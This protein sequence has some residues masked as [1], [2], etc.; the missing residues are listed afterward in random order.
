MVL[1]NS[2]A[3]TYSASLNKRNCEVH[4]KTCHRCGLEFELYQY[5]DRDAKICMGCRKPR[6]VRVY[7]PRT[8]DKLSAREAQVVELVASGRRN[9]EIAF[10]LHLT[11]GTI[12]V[13]VSH[14]FRKTGID[15][16]TGL[17][18]WW[19]KK[20]DNLHVSE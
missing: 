13:Y 16:R 9:K 1:L 2:R 11:L 5:R 10:T 7:R 14:I 6:T 3:L 19:L 18:R 12:K 20:S 8:G 17:V 15:S 4:R